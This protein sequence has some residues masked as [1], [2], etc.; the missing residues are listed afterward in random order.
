[1]F[2]KSILTA[3]ILGVA[4][5]AATAQA[6]P[7]PPPGLVISLPEH[8]MPPPPEAGPEAF[9][10]FLTDVI[11]LIDTDGDGR[12]SK[13]ELMAWMAK[14]APPMEGDEAGMRGVSE[15]SPSLEGLPYPPECS[16]ELNESELTPQAEGVAC[17]RSES[18]GNVL[19]RTVCN[20]D[21]Y[22]SNAISLPEGRAA[23]CFGIEAIKGHH[24][25]FEIVEE[26]TG[27]VM[28]DTSMGKAAFQTLVLESGPSGTVYRINL[29][30][31]DEADARITIRFIDH[32]TF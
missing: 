26:A 31:A 22:N 8:M 2:R 6:P 19:F 29:L 13:E 7:P 15:G 3:C 17:A 12:I 32:P 1:M 28:F 25:L 4:A 18:V 27:A 16:A 23:D 10:A 21:P 24:I 30:S 14:S 20:S 5:L 9:D 11:G